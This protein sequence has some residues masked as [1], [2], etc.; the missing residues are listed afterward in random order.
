[1]A[2]TVDNLVEMLNQAELIHERKDNDHILVPYGT[3][4]F[5]NH[6]GDKRLVTVLVLEENGELLRMF[7]PLAFKAD[8]RHRDAVLRACMMVHWKTKLLKFE[9]DDS[10]G[11][12]R[13][14]IELSIEDST[15][16]RQQVRRCLQALVG[17]VDQYCHV[18]Q[19]AQETGEV[20]FD[21]PPTVEADDSQIP[22]GLEGDRLQLQ[23]LRRRLAQLEASRAAPERLAAL[24]ME[25]TDLEKSLGSEPP[26]EI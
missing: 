12:I 13:P 3:E 23:A 9:Y 18:L 21:A 5:V 11:E 14:A 20:V 10:D 19:R 4:S 24:R 2:I 8:G 17:L 16:S 7:A 6:E 15:P 1:M 26:D 22:E 25:I